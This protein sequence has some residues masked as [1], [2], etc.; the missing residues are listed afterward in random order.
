[1][2]QRDLGTAIGIRS[3]LVNAYELGLA[4]PTKLQRRRIAKALSL[5]EDALWGEDLLRVGVPDNER[6]AA[7]ARAFGLAFRL[8]RIAADLT[9]VDVAERAGVPAWRL[10]QIEMGTGL[11]A[12]SKMKRQLSKSLEKGLF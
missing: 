4:G 7:K 9:Q 5:A 8:R 2:S 6:Q 1:M 3:G 10:G 11:L 12:D